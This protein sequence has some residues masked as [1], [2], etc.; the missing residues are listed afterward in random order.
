MRAGNRHRVPEH[1]PQM[2][3]CFTG[4]LGMGLPL[5][6]VVPEDPNVLLA[7]AFEKPLLR[8]CKRS[9]AIAACR[10]IA[11]RILGLPE[12]ISIR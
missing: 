7:A 11:K 2:L 3:C 10:R 4:V 9:P 5:L 8:Y 12:P 6:G 1:P